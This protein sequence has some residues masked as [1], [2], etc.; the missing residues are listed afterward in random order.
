M[1]A[2]VLLAVI[3]ISSLAF[4]SPK[5]EDSKGPVD[6]PQEEEEEIIEILEIL[7][8]YELFQD[9]ET[10]EEEEATGVEKEKRNR[11]NPGKYKESGKEW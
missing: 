11:P 5:V 9:M 10:L 4:G 6:I 1:R 8:E 3:F 7:E 2:F